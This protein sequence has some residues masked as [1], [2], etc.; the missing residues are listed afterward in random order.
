MLCDARSRLR[1][2]TFASSASAYC[3]LRVMAA[4]ATLSAR[5]AQRRSYGSWSSWAWRSASVTDGS[6]A[7]R[8]AG[9][10]PSSPQP[11]P[12]AAH[13]TSPVRIVDVLMAHLQVHRLV[14]R[15][16]PGPL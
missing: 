1:P 12:T 16:G 6:L 10:F 2:G 14:R 7:A 15:E 11:A 9:A 5:S 13:S 4:E 3:T 8:S